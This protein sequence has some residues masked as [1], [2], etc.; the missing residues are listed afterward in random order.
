MK[1]PEQCE[2]L[3]EIRMEIDRLDQHLIGTLAARFGY[4]KAAARFKKD[5]TAVADPDRLKAMLAQRRL[6]AEQQGL[7]PQV[8]EKLFNDLVKYFI[9]EEMKHWEGSPS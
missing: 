3:A 5:Q 8:V 6:W 4:V 7:N 1:S 9:A 2:S